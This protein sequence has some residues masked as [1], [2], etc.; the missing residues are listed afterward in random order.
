M[1][2]KTQTDTCVRAHVCV[3]CVSVSI[4]QPLTSKLAVLLSPVGAVEGTTSCRS[5]PHAED[6][7]CRTVTLCHVPFK[8]AVLEVVHLRALT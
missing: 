4:S 5:N 2:M 8:R 3:W 7:H 1:D 6:A